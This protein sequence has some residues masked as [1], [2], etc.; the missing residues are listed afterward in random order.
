MKKA[1]EF[2]INFTELFPS[3]LQRPKHWKKEVGAR[4]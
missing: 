4:K 2:S 1:A 3:S